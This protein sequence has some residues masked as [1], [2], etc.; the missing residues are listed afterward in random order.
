MERSKGPWIRIVDVSRQPSSYDRG[1]IPGR[2]KGLEEAGLRLGMAGPESAQTFIILKDLLGYPRV[3]IY[4]K[5]WLE[6]A[7]LQALP[8]KEQ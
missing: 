6:W 8:V 5:A 1:H 4:E 3:R 7:V 2:R